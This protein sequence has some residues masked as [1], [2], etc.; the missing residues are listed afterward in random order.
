LRNGEKFAQRRYRLRHAHAAANVQHR[1][2]RL[3]QHLQSLFDFR[4]RKINVVGYHG[5]MRIEIAL[6][7]LDIF[8]ISTST[9]TWTAGVCHLESF[10]NDARQL[11]QRL[12]E[13]TVLGA[14]QR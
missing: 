5:E 4:M 8:G 10:S 13:E 12:H 6:S 9:G 14:G 11:F 7:Q 1:L 3:S 2:L